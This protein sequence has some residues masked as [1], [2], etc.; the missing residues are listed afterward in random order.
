MLRDDARELVNL[1]ASPG[2]HCAVERLE[3]EAGVE[4]LQR[5]AAD[6]INHVEV[7]ELR[8]QQLDQPCV[9]AS[10]LVRGKGVR[11]PALSE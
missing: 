8:H 9:D 4:P 1:L 3:S 10:V 11:P 6:K 7:V 5:D 2:A